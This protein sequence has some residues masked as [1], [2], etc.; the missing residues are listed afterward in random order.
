MAKFS[1]VNETGNHLAVVFF[2]KETL[3]EAGWE[4]KESSDG[5]TYNASGDEWASTS[6]VA[7]ASSWLRIA[8]PANRREI[9]FKHKNVLN[10]DDWYVGYSS[11]DKFIGGSPDATTPPT[12]TDEQALWGT[13]AG[14]VAVD[15]FASTT[16]THRI[17]VVAESTPTSGVYPFWCFSHLQGANTGYFFAGCD[18]MLPGSFSAESTPSAP[19][20]GDADPC[21]FV[22]DNGPA[23]AQMASIRSYSQW[24]GWFRYNF[25]DQEFVNFEGQDG[26]FADNLGNSPWGLVEGFPLHW[27]RVSAQVS[28]IGHKGYGAFVK[29][30]SNNR[31]LFE[32]VNLNSGAY[33]H[34]HDL[35]LPWPDN[36]PHIL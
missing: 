16:E 23:A 17:H 36:T 3:V 29:W 14:Q 2:L 21:V 11:L 32:T 18:P 27:G 6:E 26:S 13:L 19:T 8:D 28:G 25:G 9:L 20:T 30:A 22:I 12:A 15:M 35:L 33:I 10:D 34:I 7:G 1:N 31:N 4:V 24:K 5:S